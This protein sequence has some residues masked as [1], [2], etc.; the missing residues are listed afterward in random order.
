MLP[1]LEAVLVAFHRHPHALTQLVEDDVETAYGLFGCASCLCVSALER[2]D[3]L[4]LDRGT[5]VGLIEMLRALVSPSTDV[6][7]STPQKN[8]AVTRRTTVPSAEWAEGAAARLRETPVPELPAVDL[9]FPALRMDE[10]APSKSELSMYTHLMTQANLR[11]AKEAERS[12]ESKDALVSPSDAGGGVS[13]HARGPSAPGDDEVRSDSEE[14]D[15]EEER[16]DALAR[17]REAL[18]DGVPDDTRTISSSKRGPGSSSTPRSALTGASASNDS[19]AS[20]LGLELGLFTTGLAPRVRTDPLGIP[21]LEKTVPPVGKAEGLARDVASYAAESLRVQSRLMRLCVDW[22]THA[23]V[24]SAHESED[25]D[26][27]GNRSSSADRSAMTVSALAALCAASGPNPLVAAAAVRDAAAAA[28]ALGVTLAT[29]ASDDAAAALDKARALRTYL[30][31]ALRRHPAALANVRACL[32]AAFLQRPLARVPPLAPDASH[33]KSFSE[34]L[35]DRDG[36]PATNAFPR[37]VLDAGPVWWL[38]SLEV[39][40][41]FLEDCVA[42]SHSLGESVDAARSFGLG[43][44]VLPPNAHACVGVAAAGAAADLGTPRRREDIV[45]AVLS[46]TAST[47]DAV[48]GAMLVTLRASTVHHAESSNLARGGYSGKE[49]GVSGKDAG[50]LA[51]SLATHALALIRVYR[52]PLAARHCDAIAA[53]LSHVSRAGL[54]PHTGATE[55]VRL[56]SDVALGSS[57]PSGLSL[58]KALIPRECRVEHAIRVVVH[59]ASPPAGLLAVAAGWLVSSLDDV[60]VAKGLWERCMGLIAAANQSS[61]RRLGWYRE[62]AEGG[63]GNPRLMPRLELCLLA[64]HRMDRATRAVAL[65]DAL[66]TFVSSNPARGDEISRIA[67]AHV[68]LVCAHCARYFRETPRWLVGRVQGTMR[69]G[70]T[71]PPP[72]D[73]GSTTLMGLN[74]LLAPLC[75]GGANHE[76]KKSR[77]LRG[78]MVSLDAETIVSVRAAAFALAEAPTDDSRVS[79]GEGQ[80]CRA[81]ARRAAWELLNALPDEI[82]ENGESI[83]GSP[84]E[85]EGDAGTLGFL[86]RL[87]RA[88]R[89]VLETSSSSG[90]RSVPPSLVKAMDAAAA[91]LGGSA[92]GND[93]EPARTAVVC[94]AADAACRTTALIVSARRRSASSNDDDN[95]AAVSGVPAWA[96]LAALCASIANSA[97][98]WTDAALTE[99]LQNPTETR[100]AIL[101]HAAG[102]PC[103]KTSPALNQVR[104]GLAEDVSA[105]TR[106]DGGWTHARRGALSLCARS[107]ASDVEGTLDP[108]AFAT[109]YLSVSGGCDDASASSAL[110]TCQLALHQALESA[111]IA[112]GADSSDLERGRDAAAAAAAA[113]RFEA[114][115]SDPATEFAWALAGEC[116]AGLSGH[117]DASR[118]NAVVAALSAS[119]GAARDRAPRPA[120]ALEMLRSSDAPVAVDAVVVAAA[121]AAGAFARGFNGRFDD[122]A[123]AEEASELLRGA[124]ALMNRDSRSCGTLR[125]SPVASFSLLTALRRLCTL[126]AAALP[127][128]AL[129]DV[130]RWRET[131]S[132]DPTWDSKDEKDSGEEDDE[133][134]DESSSSRITA[135]DW[136]LCALLTPPDE[137]E[138]GVGAMAIDGI[139]AEIAKCA[140]SLCDCLLSPSSRVRAGATS[141][142]TDLCGGGGYGRAPVALLGAMLARLPS[143]CAAHET[144]DAMRVTH[145][146]LRLAVERGAGGARAA[147]IGLAGVVKEFSKNSKEA[148]GVGSRAELKTLHAQLRT[149]ARLCAPPCVPHQAQAAAVEA[150]AGPLPPPPPPPPRRLSLPS[151]RVVADG[152]GVSRNRASETGELVSTSTSIALPASI[153]GDI[154]LLDTTETETDAEASTRADAALAEARET[155]GL[156]SAR[157][158]GAL[159]DLATSISA[160]ERARRITT[161]LVE[162]LDLALA[163]EERGT[164][165]GNDEDERAPAAARHVAGALD[166][167]VDR[168]FEQVARAAAAAARGGIAGRSL[169]AAVGL[170]LDDDDD[171]DMDDTEASDFAAAVARQHRAAAAAAS[172]GRARL[173]RSGLGSNFAISNAVQPG[174]VDPHV[175]TFVSSGS[176]FMEQHW[177]FCYTCDLTVSKGCCGACAKACH[178]GHTVVYS[179]RSRF[180][181]D[182]GAGSI[183]AHECQCLIPRS[184]TETTS[185]T[186]SGVPL[187]GD[188]H[189]DTSLLRDEK[190]CMK[191]QTG[192]VPV[193]HESDSEMDES[194]DD[195]DFS[196]LDEDEEIE[197]V[198]DLTSDP[199]HSKAVASLRTSLL[200]SPG[201]TSSLVALCDR[202]VDH[203]CAVDLQELPARRGMESSV[204]LLSLPPPFELAPLPAPP[205]LLIPD[206][207]VTVLAV[208]GHRPDLVHLRRG[209]KAGSFEVRPRPE[210]AARRELLPAIV[211]G[212]LRRSALSCARGSGVLAVAE[213]DTVCVLDAGALAGCGG[214]GSIVPVPNSAASSSSEQRVG[215]RPL[216]RSGVKFEVARVLFNPA[217]DEYL[218]VAGYAQCVVF[219]LGAKGEVLDRLCVGPEEWPL[220]GI[221]GALLDVDWIPGSTSLL[222]LTVAAHVAVFDLAKS[223][224]APVLTVNL[225]PREGEV[226]GSIPARIAASAL[227][228]HRGQNRVLV[229]SEG[230]AL[231][232]HPLG[233]NDKGDA[234]VDTGNKLVLPECVRGREGLS[235][236]FSR[237]HGVALVSFD[238][239][240]TV[241]LRLDPETGAVNASCVVNEDAGSSPDGDNNGGE[242]TSLE[243]YPFG[244]TGFSHWSEACAPPPAPLAGAAPGPIEPPAPIFVAS[245]AR[246]DGAVCVVSLGGETPASQ[247]LR[248]NPEH[249]QST[250]TARG[251]VASSSGSTRASTRESAASVVANQPGVCGSA[252]FQPNNLDV[253]FLFTL[254]DDGSLQVF[255]QEPP[256]PA[257]VAAADVQQKQLARAALTQADRA[258]TAAKLRGAR[259]DVDVREDFENGDES[260]S[261]NASRNAFPLDF[262]ERTQCVTSDVT[263]GGDLAQRVSSDSLRFA[264]QSEDSHVEAPAPGACE[265]TMSLAKA[266]HVIVGLRV[267][268]GNSGS[269]QCPTELVIGAAPTPTPNAVP[270]APAPPPGVVLPGGAP[271]VSSSESRLTDGRRKFPFELGARRWYDIPLTRLESVA[272]ERDLAVTLG[273]AASPN[274]R[275]RVDHLEVYSMPKSEF[276]WE[277]ACDEAAEAAAL[278]AAGDAEAAARDGCIDPWEGEATSAGRM[279]R[280]ARHVARY[281]GAMSINSDFTDEERVLCTSLSLLEKSARCCGDVATADAVARLSLRLLIPTIVPKDEV[282][283]EIGNSPR[284][285]EADDDADGKKK[286]PAVQTWVP[287]I[288]ARRLAWRVLRAALTHVHDDDTDTAAAAAARKDEATIA[289]VAEAAVKLVSVDPR[290]GPSPADAA[291]FH[292][293]C[294]VAARVAS[295]R[296]EAFASSPAA[297][298]AVT[299]L[300]RASEGM[301]EAGAGAWD[302]EETAPALAHAVVALAHFE[303]PADEL[304]NSDSG[305]DVD[306]DSAAVRLARAM[307]LAGREDSRYAAAN[308]I[309]DAL[310]APA[311]AHPAADYARCLLPAVE[312][313]S[314]NQRDGKIS[315]PAG[316]TAP[317]ISISQAA[318]TTPRPAP[319][320]TELTQFS[321]DQCDKSPVLGVRW[322]CTRCLDFDLC[323]ECHRESSRGALYPSTHSASHPMICYRVG[324]KPPGP[325]VGVGDDAQAAA[326]SVS[327][328]VSSSIEFTEVSE[329]KARLVAALAAADDGV[330]GAQR[331]AAE[332]SP[333]FV[334]LRRLTTVPRYAAAMA[335][336]VIG[337]AAE[338]AAAMRGDLKSP[339]FV[340]EKLLLRISLLSAVLAAKAACADVD[341]PVWDIG[342]PPASLVADLRAVASSLNAS[343]NETPGL[344]LDFIAPVESSSGN[345]KRVTIRWGDPSVHDADSASELVRERD[346]ADAADEPG[347]AG[348]GALLRPVPSF[349]P[350]RFACESRLDVDEKLLETCVA[351]THQLVKAPELGPSSVSSASKPSRRLGASGSITPRVNTPTGRRGSMNPMICLTAADANA[352]TDTLASLLANPRRLKSSGVRVHARKLLLRVAK[353]RDAYHAARDAAALEVERFRFQT[354]ALPS[355]GPGLAERAPHAA[356][357]AALAAL[358]AAA[359][360]AQC[361]PKSWRR[362]VFRY[363]EF[364][365]R[366]AAAAPWMGEKAQLDALKL[367]TRAMTGSSEVK[368]P[369]VAT[370][371]LGSGGRLRVIRPGDEYSAMDA[372]R[373]RAPDRAGSG[374]DAESILRDASNAAALAIVATG[375]DAFARE[376]MVSHPSRAV[377]AAAAGAARAAWRTAPLGSSHRMKIAGGIFALTSTLANVGVAASEACAF[378]TWIL[379]TEA[380]PGSIEDATRALSTPGVV[381]RLVDELARNTRTL[382]TH[383]NAGTYE[384]LRRYVDEEDDGYYLE[385]DPVCFSNG[386]SSESAASLGYSGYSGD[387]F[388]RQK[389]DGGRAELCYTER[390]VVARLHTRSS[391]KTIT[392]SLHNPSRVRQVRRLSL[393][394]AVVPG[395][396]VSKLKADRSAWQRIATCTLAPGANEAVVDLP[397]PLTCSALVVEFTGFH[398]D[399][400][401]KSQEMTQCPR[402]SRPVTDR[403]G[404]CGHCRENAHQCRHCRNINYEHLDAFICNECGHS[405]HARVEVS[406]HAVASSIYPRILTEED[407]ARAVSDLETE[408]SSAARARDVVN[409][410]MHQLRQMLETSGNDENFVRPALSDPSTSPAR[411]RAESDRTGNGPKLAGVSS[412]RVGKRAIDIVSMYGERCAAAHAQAAAAERRRRDVLT[413]LAER[414]GSSSGVDNR[415]TGGDSGRFQTTPDVSTAFPATTNYG[416][417][418]AFVSRVLPLCVAIADLDAVRDELVRAAKGPNG[419]AAALTRHRRFL[420]SGSA[421]EDARALLLALARDDRDGSIAEDACGVIE[422]RA[423]ALFGVSSGIEPREPGSSFEFTESHCAT[424]ANAESIELVADDCRLLAGLARVCAEDDDADD[425]YAYDGSSHDEATVAGGLPPPP[426]PTGGIRDEDEEEDEDEDGDDTEP[427]FSDGAAGIDV[428]TLLRDDLARLAGLD[429]DPAAAAPRSGL[430]PR[431]IA[432]TN[433]EPDVR[434]EGVVRDVRSDE[435]ALTTIA[436]PTPVRLLV[437]LAHRAAHAGLTRDAGTCERVIMPALRLLRGVAALP[438]ICRGR[439]SRATL[440]MK[441]PEPPRRTMEDSLGWEPSLA[442]KAR[443]IRIGRAWRDRASVRRRRALSG[444]GSEVLLSPAAGDQSKNAEE[445]FV[446]FTTLTQRNAFAR[447]D[448][449]DDLSAVEGAAAWGVRMLLAPGS[450][451][452]RAEAAALV[453]N[454][455]ADGER[456]RFAVL[457][458]LADALPSVRIAVDSTNARA[459]EGAGICEEYFDTLAAVMDEGPSVPAAAAAR[460]YLRTFKKLPKLV[461]SEMTQETNRL[462]RADTDTTYGPP[463]HDTDAGTLLRRLAELLVKLIGCH[464]GG[465]DDGD[466]VTAAR[467]LAIPNAIDSITRCSLALRSLIVS[468]TASTTATEYELSSLIDR[469]TAADDGAREAA[470]AAVLAEAA[471]TGPS[472][473]VA[474]GLKSSD[475]SP[476]AH[477]DPQQPLLPPAPAGHVLAWL[478]KLLLPTDQEQDASYRLRLVKSST[479]EEFIRGQMTKNPYESAE[480]ALVTMRDVK[481]FVCV[482]LDMHGLCDDDFGM[483]LLVA[484]KIVSLDLT[485]AEV[486]EH[487]WR[488]AVESGVNGGVNGNVNGV[489]AD[490]RA[491]ATR[492]R[493]RHRLVDDDDDDDDDDQYDA[494]DRDVLGSDRS[495]ATCPPMVVTYRLQGLDGEATEEMV[496]EIDADAAAETDPEVTFAICATLRTHR[497]LD[498]LLSLVPLLSSSEASNSKGGTYGQIDS[499]SLTTPSSETAST[500]MRLLNAAAELAGNRRAMLAARALPTLLAEAGRLFGADSDAAEE[501]GNELLLLVERLLTEE[502]AMGEDTDRASPPN[503]IPP[504]ANTATPNA[505]ALA[506]GG[507]T[508]SFSRGAL[509]GNNKQSSQSS[510]SSPPGPGTKPVEVL[511]GHDAADVARQVEV[512]LVKLAELTKGGGGG[513]KGA[514][515]RAASTLAR[516]LPRL[517]AGDADA[518]RA[519]ATHVAASVARLRDLDSLAAGLPGAETLALELRCC[520]LVVE[521][522]PGDGDASGTRLKSALHEKGALR[523][524]TGYLLDVAFNAPGARDLDK[525]SDAWVDAC[526]RPALPHALATLSGLIRS[527]PEGVEY[528]AGCSGCD[529]GSDSGSM[530]RLLHALEPVTEHGVGTLSEN[531]LQCIKQMDAD[532]AET[533]ATL[534]R[535]TKATQMQ[536]A[537]ER[538]EKMLK[539]MGLTRLSPASPSMGGESMSPGSP[540][541]SPSPGSYSMGA[542]DDRFVTP[543]GS[544]MGGAHDILTVAVSPT[545]MLGIEDISDEEEDDDAALVCR[546]CREGYR[547]RPRE[548]MGVYCFCKRVDCAPAAT[549]SPAVNSANTT[550]VPGYATVSHFNAIHFA[551][552]AAARRAD[553]ALRTPKREWEGASLRN[554]ETLCNNLLPVF[555]GRVGD[556]SF[557]RAAGAWWENVAAAVGKTEPASARLRLALADVSMLLGRFATGANG[558]FSADCHGGGR[559]SNMRVVPF[560]LQLAAHELARDPNSHPS[561]SASSSR[562]TN[563]AVHLIEAD[564]DDDDVDVNSGVNSSRSNVRRL[565]LRN[566]AAARSALDRL[567]LGDFVGAAASPAFPAALALSVLITPLDDWTR[568]RRDALRAAV[569]HARREGSRCVDGACGVGAARPEV[570]ERHESPHNPFEQAKPILIYVGLV[571]KLQRW[572]KPSGG[573]SPLRPTPSAPVPVGGGGGMGSQSSSLAQL[574]AEAEDAIAAAAA[575]LDAAESDSADS[576]AAAAASV[577]TD[578]R[579]RLRDLPAMSE[580]SK[581]TLEW[582]EDVETSEDFLELFDSMELLGDV[583]TDGTSSADEFVEEASALR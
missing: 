484:G 356:T 419:L 273:A 247:P 278:A 524:V 62:A 122:G 293:A 36:Q 210:N 12:K 390:A 540:A 33:P 436:P 564:D 105:V 578:V 57:T 228:C 222:A 189:A 207:D 29:T 509:G 161:S 376:L 199:S 2:S 481:N 104:A 474:S 428:G 154:G 527:H 81:Y 128:V 131:A 195:Y 46:P 486:F 394:R 330:L 227:A 323:D 347:V 242:D 318:S 11:A 295:R 153:D 220:D 280:A 316:K 100:A 83:I 98:R 63:D 111:A 324:P 488:T 352:W 471:R 246:L 453:R 75:D 156:L 556:A 449:D 309:T 143:L 170:D 259:P 51:T 113:A 238:G 361:R 395:V 563:A 74:A 548:L 448:D 257:G 522:I 114:I 266:G 480:C 371:G 344:G 20:G 489:N 507:L 403:H 381:A 284:S 26:E 292:A 264:L 118:S 312:Y 73:G 383:P 400:H 328:A 188:T 339:A 213:G 534:R 123:K 69:G 28:L 565:N 358:S 479:Q 456:N 94:A 79:P 173:N 263:F 130:S 193:A 349:G 190:S 274:T 50:K 233:P 256:P 294:R 30:G 198:T 307:L 232:S 279:D 212:T 129:E 420:G 462:T 261:R 314:E 326:S 135:R 343:F 262:F 506:P 537:M 211:M 418:A 237:A 142:T 187:T 545:S 416:G 580:W 494:G 265:V 66:S 497:G 298:A 39:G 253:A 401:A 215:I 21:P 552:H 546:V 526:A 439:S 354:A 472:P 334:L 61:E 518:T 99:K 377:R 272:A 32:A 5:R 337:A 310:I 429:I 536:K 528:V 86:W 235:V 285:I 464:D 363:P 425:S 16:E 550:A 117:M 77:R 404:V 525:A 357:L 60:D 431:P 372:A 1:T 158:L 40:L 270:K 511:R 414:A 132:A 539:E 22:E 490:P 411:R 406:I 445:H 384:R 101:M 48:M 513:T 315:I 554:S 389:L 355:A 191:K 434:I 34:F 510:Q 136:V 320:G 385:A 127:G 407:A 541:M 35:L 517:A 163:N 392:V 505:I 194:P 141:L 23:D 234:V 249:V 493:G 573:S 559:E 335:P 55:A 169:A 10:P 7:S 138:G 152:E 386:F 520:A 482:S 206:R 297:R 447:E 567:M 208:T 164:G 424:I 579:E 110:L 533:I 103:A 410:L 502:T 150:I 25:D 70:E 112:I 85:L 192:V 197:S 125:L 393:Y 555:A 500:L 387:V 209:F 44:V 313:S 475:S 566:A 288:D 529:T 271:R 42:G 483:E 260:E 435:P 560:V 291:P 200:S 422:A 24:S 95:A 325:G 225:P 551:C 466:G 351:L 477:T 241:L 93:D 306:H 348:C 166:E 221:D 398:V 134:A 102:S 49:A 531:A 27:T 467:L 287:S 491:A 43:G 374:S 338:S 252:G 245:S 380:G 582:L 495:H 250:T 19:E 68:A 574:A 115:A 444:F 542:G 84:F 547:S 504:N 92:V 172:S 196:G 251:G 72:P 248:S 254:R 345:G 413:A 359:D 145:L 333:Y 382:A 139:R 473:L 496:S 437:K 543:L 89:S 498:A 106:A 438:A 8:T 217:A 147:A 508:R 302:A 353:T 255:A 120:A 350:V 97:R 289:A 370:L 162:D 286:K 219:T 231:Y 516:V 319:P 366:V 205:R 362:F 454:V 572:L 203:L 487:V 290:R 532:A 202:A 523:A 408:S 52:A 391:V 452:V 121:E 459:G 562:S 277:A 18:I 409:S 375:F 443:A 267:H 321:C 581:E 58:G 503:A 426:T 415:Q 126:D 71:T 458:L 441:F 181:C 521:G 183:P 64:F 501:T 442:A 570:D 399:P 47:L 177:Y 329:G 308:A 446:D 402:C 549:N 575:A 275:V 512:F 388:K 457:S 346:I 322:H 558:S 201:L 165:N 38:A 561:G 157:R 239:G 168:E 179:R 281:R 538:R 216:S 336:A 155:L 365:A 465:R 405:R 301:M 577:L 140:E 107:D 412:V 124:A 342:P 499:R 119:R 340:R 229:L 461:V 367:L 174:S 171:S 4:G 15:S 108:S 240:S 576:A 327:S 568:R 430:P 463:P 167:L 364:L 180:F 331:G 184:S 368:G 544:P 379:S 305:G 182:C 317:P 397:Y 369:P 37:S 535:A 460:M 569:A 396:S 56:L 230:G 78:G 440:A 116:A 296:P 90:D 283:D 276:G 224:V 144:V 433:T 373:G 133:D 258:A 571:D 427:F 485:V 455:A 80:R 530:L 423:N 417:A 244:P 514:A 13:G 341:S 41:G 470:I 186:S 236:H 3:T 421:R 88:C 109:A 31:A 269:T 149:L 519:L 268:L 476:R 223:A 159:G 175:C 304:I 17:C 76:K 478:A 468:R 6:P 91:S 243:R 492:I 218:A 65:A 450:A 9:A 226:D 82:D 185:S 176:S 378:A 282:N 299:A 148:S 553:I 67:R 54:D 87:S 515:S 332:L 178:V 59:A 311:A 557:A 204:A 360:V 469:A 160:D 146:L 583:L 432:H 303:P 214:A 300:V 53:A 451:D 45:P 137:R 151:S 96:T 14:Y